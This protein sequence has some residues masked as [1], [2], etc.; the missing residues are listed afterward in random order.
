VRRSSAQSQLRERTSSVS[1]PAA[2]ERDSAPQRGAVG[3]GRGTLPKVRILHR[4]DRSRRGIGGERSSSKGTWA[5]EVDGPAHFL[6]SRAPTRA[7]LLTQPHLQLLSH[8]SSA[9]APGCGASA[10]LRREEAAPEGQACTLCT[11]HISYM[12]VVIK[13]NS[14]AVCVR[15]TKCRD[16]VSQ[17]SPVWSTSVIERPLRVRRAGADDANKTADVSDR[18]RLGAVQGHQ[19][20]HLERANRMVG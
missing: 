6:T 4:H 2:S 14:R 12:K 3:G 13:S 10:G 7:T 11:F 20:R 17:Y 18:R 16:K 1:E 15:V 5:V 19:P 8:A 9:C